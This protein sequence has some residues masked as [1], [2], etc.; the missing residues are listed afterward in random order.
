VSAFSSPDTPHLTFSSHETTSSAFVWACYL[1][2]I[3]PDMQ[4]ILRAEI[5]D[6]LSGIEPPDMSSVMESMPYLNGVLLEAIRLYPTAPVLLRVAKVDTPLLGTIVPK[7]TTM[8]IAPWLINRSP[9][10]WGS[11]ADEFRPARWIGANGKPNHTGGGKTP[12]LS[13]LHG[14]R[15]CIGENFSKAELRCLL[16]AMARRFEWELDMPQEKV[17]PGGAVTIRPAFGLHVKLKLIDV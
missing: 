13:F 16:V 10:Y 4:A 1:L 11:D 15:G 2:S 3:N 5:R 7:N 8:V 6:A 14:P 12:I 9:E 17:V